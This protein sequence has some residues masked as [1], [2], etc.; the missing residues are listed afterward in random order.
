VL[1]KLLWATDWGWETLAGNGEE[2]RGK[3]TNRGQKKREQGSEV[4]RGYTHLLLI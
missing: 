3:N 2:S 4:D 1:Q